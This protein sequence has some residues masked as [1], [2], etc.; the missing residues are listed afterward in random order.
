MVAFLLAGLAGIC[1]GAM[2]VAVRVG[3]TRAPNAVLA[4][5]LTSVVGCVVVAIAA[6]ATGD[7]ARSN[8]GQLWRFAAIGLVVPGLSQVVFVHAIRNAGPSR[9]AIL[10]GTAPVMSAA[11]AVT[12]LDES[13]GVALGIATALI[14]AGG[15][16]LAREGARPVD[17]RM[18]GAAAALACA[19]LFA[20]RDNLV[21]V[22][23]RSEDIPPLAGATASLTGA[24]LALLVF[25]LVVRR[26]R[27]LGGAMLPTLR[28]FLPSGLF[29]GAAYAALLEAL[30][31]GT[32][33]VVAPLNATQ[34]L[35]ALLLSAVVLRRTEM[36]GRRLVVAAVLI[37]A[38][39][40]LIGATR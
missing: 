10:I 24:T 6:G 30:D 35:W 32:V 12:F 28:A 23:A 3:L 31:R 15:A 16:L 9:A 5:F 2:T 39:S 34:S 27:D 18:I 40:V 22:V 8:A 13:L 11:I 1:F 33:T 25:L 14:V 36:I 21:R 7:L 38:G 17:F 20:F 37:V 19:L 29:L 4:P 26:G